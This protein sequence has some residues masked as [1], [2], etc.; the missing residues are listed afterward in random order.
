MGF[1]AEEIRYGRR[2]RLFI[3]VATIAGARA[4]AYR[5]RGNMRAD[6]N[7]GQRVA[8]GD[9]EYEQAAGGYKSTVGI[10]RESV[11]SRFLGK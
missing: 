9:S 4:A 8:T 10:P 5:I 11:R 3:D 7:T 6:A 2:V 1:R